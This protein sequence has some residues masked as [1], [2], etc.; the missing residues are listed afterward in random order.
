[1]MVG[2]ANQQTL[3]V[4]R[5]GIIR[6]SW[7]MLLASSLFWGCVT[8]LGGPIPSPEEELF[9][10]DFPATATD[11]ASLSGSGDEPAAYLTM[12]YTEALGRA[13]DPSGWQAYLGLFRSQGCT[14]ETL[15]TV[16]NSIFLS[17]EYASLG[18]GHTARLLTLYRGI[19]GRE[20]DAPGY[21][22]HLARMEAGRSF[23][24]SVGIFVGSGE[25]RARVP[26]LC[27]GERIG[28]G[29][30]RVIDVQVDDTGAFG[31]SAWGQ[32]QGDLEALLAAAAARGGGTVVLERRA[33]VR[34]RRKLV[35]PANVTLKT[36]GD[37]TPRRY[38][39]MARL[40]R[41]ANVGG[42]GLVT[43]SPGARLEGVWVD[44]QNGKWTVANGRTEGVRTWGSNVTVAN[45]RLSDSMGTQIYLADG[46][47]DGITDCVNTVVRDNL[48][49]AYAARYNESSP[50]MEWYSDGITN[51]CRAATIAR[52]QIVDATDIGIVT[53]HPGGAMAQRSQVRDNRIVNAGNSAVAGIGIDP[54]TGFG[55][56][57]NTR[58]SFAGFVAER[59][60][61]WTSARAHIGLLLTAGTRGWF[62]DGVAVGGT[63]RNND[64]GGLRARTNAGIFVATMDGPTIQGNGL[65]MTIGR[66]NGCPTGNIVISSDSVNVGQVQGPWTRASTSSIIGCVARNGPDRRN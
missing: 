34:L 49:T 13:P 48:I 54:E 41:D 10:G 40:V 50:F 16:V 33:V 58:H 11:S 26:G 39:A 38:A 56:Q 9:G 65:L 55:S 29:A 51:R 42:G 20:P 61:M 23:A 22:N 63:M 62:A 14:H 32:N 45:S 4:D 12:L 35:V 46:A 27:S 36:A 5:R 66:Y 30:A 1:M 60:S 37:Q 28:W 24:E 2:P 8:E 31:G 47:R 7:G 15:R 25:F 52:N 21:A 3:R 6:A 44:G 19:L 57:A 53:F 59:N 18:Y 64:T 17:S 43:L